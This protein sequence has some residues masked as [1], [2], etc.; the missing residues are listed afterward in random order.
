[1]HTNEEWRAVVG[2]EGRYEVSDQGRVRTVLTDGFRPRKFGHST[3]GRAQVSLGRGVTANVHVIVAA[4]FIGPRPEGMHVCHSNGDHLDNRAANLR[5]DT[6]SGNE[7][8]KRLHGTSHEANK[9]HCPS[10]H[11]Y[12]DENTRICP[13]GSRKCRACH[14]EWERQRRQRAA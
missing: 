13:D 2:F 12:N 3:T 11:A 9:T 8:D 1:M 5:Y 14:R 4:A 7:R 10:G 6:P